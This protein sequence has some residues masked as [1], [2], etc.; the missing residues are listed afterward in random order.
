VSAV[1][2]SWHDGLRAWQRR[3][4]WR[5]C[6]ESSKRRAWLDGWLAGAVTSLASDPNALAPFHGKLVTPRTPWRAE[7][8]DLVFVARTTLSPLSY[9]QL[10]LLLGRSEGS[11]RVRACRLDIPRRAA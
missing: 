11:I 1:G 6:P 9:E 10:A 2:A 7:E 5:C 4:S 3:A 8:L